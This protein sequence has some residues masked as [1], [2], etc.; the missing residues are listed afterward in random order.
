MRRRQRERLDFF[1]ELL[2][3]IRALLHLPNCYRDED[4]IK[5]YY[6]NEVLNTLVEGG[7]IGER[8]DVKIKLLICSIINDLSIEVDLEAVCVLATRPYEPMHEVEPRGE[9]TL[10]DVVHWTRDDLECDQE[11][12]D[13]WQHFVFKIL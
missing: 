4:P 13:Q 1:L 11:D 12:F 2:R 10:E 3:G 9:H 7:F 6:L 5:E 8:L